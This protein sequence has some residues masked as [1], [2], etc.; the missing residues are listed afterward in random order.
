MGHGALV[1][2][3]ILERHVYNNK[4]DL[5]NSHK[6]EAISIKLWKSTDSNKTYQ[7]QTYYGSIIPYESYCWC[8]FDNKTEEAL[9]PETN[10]N[11]FSVA[12]K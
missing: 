1:H 4:Y 3:Q 12:E 9:K 2:K 7:Y 8:M 5:C 6:Q 10:W 11:D